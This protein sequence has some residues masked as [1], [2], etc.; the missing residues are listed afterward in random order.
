MHELTESD[1]LEA[2]G[3]GLG[4]SRIEQALALI[5]AADVERSFAQLASLPIGRRD[6]LLLDLRQRLFGPT[7]DC[8]VACQA[9]GEALEITFGLDEIRAP[10]AAPPAVLAVEVDGGVVHARLPN[11]YDLLAA[12]ACGDRTSARLCLLGRC[13]DADPRGLPPETVEVIAAHMA[14]ADPQANVEIMLEC[15][16]CRC[17][18]PAPFDIAAFLWAEVDAW[19]RRTLREVHMLARAYGWREAQILTMSATRRRAYI[20]LVS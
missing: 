5:A 14:A 1:I 9:C 11:S 7:C 4:Q 17:E 15:L 19:A 8:V 13:L 16:G 18:W 20:E 10:P 3:R 6:T 12:R 2:W